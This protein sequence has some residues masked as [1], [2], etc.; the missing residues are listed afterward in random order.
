MRCKSVRP[1]RGKPTRKQCGACSGIGPTCRATL[2][3]LCVAMPQSSWRP[4]DAVTPGRLPAVG[5]SLRA[6]ARLLRNQV[7]N[8]RHVP[9][10]F[11]A[12]ARVSA[13]VAQLLEEVAGGG[14]E[15]LD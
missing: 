11:R 13:G 10:H 8:P 3:K 12:G 2:S 9:L 1:E 6:G 7:P 14:L 5:Q 4:W 15:V